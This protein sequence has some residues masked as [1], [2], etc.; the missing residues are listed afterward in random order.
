MATSVDTLT[1][2]RA[3]RCVWC[4]GLSQSQATKAMVRS[5]MAKLGRLEAVH[6]RRKD[7]TNK[8]WAL[9]LFEDAS[10]VRDAL[11]EATR[12]R[13]GAA[14]TT[15]WKVQMVEPARLRS[16]EANFA[17]VSVVDEATIA[18]E[19][20]AQ[21][22]G[23]SRGKNRG[24]GGLTVTIDDDAAA[25]TTELVRTESAGD[26]MERMM[27]RYSEER[28]AEEEERRIDP[29]PVTDAEAQEQAK[30]RAR[31]GPIVPDTPGGSSPAVGTTLARRG[32]FS[33]ITSK[34]TEAQA[35]LK[36]G[37]KLDGERVQRSHVRHELAQAAWSCLKLD[38]AQRVGE[39][40]L[41]AAGWAAGVPLFSGLSNS[42]LRM[43]L[44]NASTLELKQGEALVKVGQPL[45]A[46]YVVRRAFPSCTWS[47]WTEIYLH[48]AVHMSPLFL[49]RN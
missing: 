16:L 23:K 5:A 1:E 14:A 49:S 42:Q 24:S 41:S 45:H 21:Y 46:I 17:L 25:A 4:G 10:S 47:I 31:F 33:S 7:G 12:V 35:A 40:L 13:L 27:S 38:P 9:V 26:R 30:L 44:S 19:T 3:R 34:K 11:C 15:C 37:S 18:S 39:P 36:N 28:A 2:E 20:R 43:V 29:T 48:T 6:V 8:S 32:R 22:K